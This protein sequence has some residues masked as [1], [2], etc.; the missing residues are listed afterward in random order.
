MLG[1]QAAESHSTTTNSDPGAPE[2]KVWKQTAVAILREKPHSE[3]CSAWSTVNGQYVH[4]YSGQQGGWT[5]RG[6]LIS[7]NR[8]KTWVVHCHRF[9]SSQSVCL[10]GAIMTDEY[11]L[12]QTLTGF[13]E[14]W[15]VQF[16]NFALLDST[17]AERFKLR[18]GAFA[19]FDLLHALFSL[20]NRLTRVGFASVPASITKKPRNRNIF[21]SFLC[22]FG[23]QSAAAAVA[24]TN[25]N[26]NATTIREEPEVKVRQK[27]N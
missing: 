17:I 26:H 4:Y 27:V 6:E 18:R 12:K 14:Y 7:T 13:W 10:H 19:K 9:P 24:H 25:H 8:R 15:E 11:I 16:D 5:G 23:A 21:S 1:H 22:C 20:S 2:W 3:V